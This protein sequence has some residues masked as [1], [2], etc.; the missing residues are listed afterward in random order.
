MITA[1]A[2][3]PGGEDAADRPP[4]VE[5]EPIPTPP[6]PLPPVAKPEFVLPAEWEIRE[7]SQI[8]IL[9]QH[10][11]GPQGKDPPTNNFASFKNRRMCA[12]GSA[13][14]ECKAGGPLPDFV[15]NGTF[16]DGQGYVMGLTMRRGILD[17]LIATG[18]KY[19]SRGIFTQL[20]NGT[21]E[22]CYGAW[23][24]PPMDAIELARRCSVNGARPREALGGG[25][26]LLYRGQRACSE[27]SIAAPCDDN[28]DLSQVQRF[29]NG[30][31]GIDAS[32]FRKTQHI[33]AALRQGHA[34][35]A[36]PRDGTAGKSGR[37]IQNDFLAAGFSDVVKFDGHSGF[38][39]RGNNGLKAGTGAN[40]SGILV[41]NAGHAGL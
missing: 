8:E 40:S 4:A 20:E 32:Q 19:Y 12:L 5:V 35:L 26:L 39:V 21:F 13:P 6:S 28:V 31:A 14:G 15:T 30:G 25:G 17:H 2:D 16:Y 29:D 34:Y 22:I 3:L 10:G 11:E 7:I 38:F 1:G 18:T 33:V 41:K 27:N 9:N 23:N 24:G 36:W 37:Q